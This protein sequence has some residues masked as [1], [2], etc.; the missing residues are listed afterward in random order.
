M[1]L[2][3][4][5]FEGRYRAAFAVP[6]TPYPAQREFSRSFAI[7]LPSGSNGFEMSEHPGIRAILT[8]PCDPSATHIA[9]SPHQHRD[10][11]VGR[12]RPQ[13]GDGDEDVAQQRRLAEPDVRGLRGDNPRRGDM[14]HRTTGAS[15]EVASTRQPRPST[16]GKTAVRGG[17]RRQSID[18]PVAVGGNAARVGPS[19]DG[20]SH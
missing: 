3:P 19:T 18:T 16:H 5:P 14:H 2:S 4:Q 13:A 1:R 20:T 12:T 9:V 15:Y 17:R 7:D 6:R 10:R 8:L 11:L